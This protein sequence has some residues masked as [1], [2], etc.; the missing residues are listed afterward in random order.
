VPKLSWNPNTITVRASCSPSAFRFCA[1]SRPDRVLARDH[2]AD[3]CTCYGAQ[4]SIAPSFSASQ[5]PLS[6][7]TPRRHAS[8]VPRGIGRPALGAGMRALHGKEQTPPITLVIRALS[9]SLEFALL[10]HNGL[11]GFSPLR[12]STRLYRLDGTTIPLSISESV[13]IVWDTFEGLSFSLTRLSRST[14]ELSRS[15]QLTN[16]CTSCLTRNQTESPTT[17]VMQ[18]FESLTHHKV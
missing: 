12:Y 3:Y 4:L 10:P 14:A 11:S 1:A 9:V 5:A 18:G 8:P 13:R 16:R 6:E 17:P 2:P 15:V 7:C